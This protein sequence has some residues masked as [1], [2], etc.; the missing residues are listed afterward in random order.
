LKWP[1]DVLYQGA[2]LAGILAESEMDARG[3]TRFIV[4]GFGV[5]L[6]EAPRLDDRATTSLREAGGFAPPPEEVAEQ[7]LL[8]LAI[9]RQRLVEEGFGAIRSAWLAAG[10]ALGEPLRVIIGESER[11]GSFAGLDDEGALLLAGP[12]GIT[13]ITAGEVLGARGGRM[14]RGAHGAD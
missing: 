4:F 12:S 2:K 5:N 8:G 1:N 6:L 9:W 10:P 7:L 14:E 3:Q 11:Q 13:V